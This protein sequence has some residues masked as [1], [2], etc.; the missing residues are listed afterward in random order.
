MLIDAQHLAGIVRSPLL[1]TVM[2]VAS[3]LLLIWG[4]VN[5]YPATTSSSPAYS[6]MLVAWS[7]SEVI[8]YSYFVFN[9]RGSVPAFVRWLRYLRALWSGNDQGLWGG[10]TRL[11]LEDR[12]YN[13]FYVLYPLGIC[14]EMWLI[15]TAIEPAKTWRVQYEYLLKIILVIYIPGIVSCH[16]L[17]EVMEL[18]NHRYLCFVHAYDGPE[19]EDDEGK[20]VGTEPPMIFG[21]VSP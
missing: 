20:A 17:A 8:R 12:R 13:T 11:I 9:L 3:R 15:Y 14:S 21:S 19:E 6:S 5:N 16:R 2:Q 4:I 7:V 10:T 18:I 1:T